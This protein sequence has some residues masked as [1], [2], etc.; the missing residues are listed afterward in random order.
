MIHLQRASAIKSRL[1]K[2][3]AD[4][5]THHARGER[6]DVDQLL[7]ERLHLA[8]TLAILTLETLA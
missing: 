6:T 4:V 5:A 7:D 1:A 3:D 8:Q 2:I